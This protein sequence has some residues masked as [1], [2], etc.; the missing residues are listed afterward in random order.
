MGKVCLSLFQI[1]YVDGKAIHLSHIVKCDTLLLGND[2][3][4]Q[5]QEVGETN[6]S[7]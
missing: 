4:P 6:K 2:R 5:S 7:I 1:N 3:L